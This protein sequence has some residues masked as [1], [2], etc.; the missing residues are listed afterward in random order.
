MP[1][2]GNKDYKKLIRPLPDFTERDIY[3]IPIIKKQDIAQVRLH[4]TF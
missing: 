4:V 2:Y 1:L 3:D